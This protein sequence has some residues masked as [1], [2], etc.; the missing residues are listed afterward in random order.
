MV[1]SQSG[2]L[3][4]G[5]VNGPLFTSD[6][7]FELDV[8]NPSGIDFGTEEAAKI[9]LDRALEK[10][11]P[12][13]QFLFEPSLDGYLVTG[14]GVTAAADLGAPESFVSALRSFS[15][16]YIREHYRAKLVF[17]EPKNLEFVVSQTVASDPGPNE[18]PIGGLVTGGMMG[19]ALFSVA[20][21][22]LSLVSEG[23]HF[24]LSRPGKNDAD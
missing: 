20:Y 17:G 13:F 4:G 23:N 21:L 7:S 22:L 3:S 14:T 19:V 1:A 15:T 16:E 2:E 12:G 18:L 10:E 5:A 6:V 24:F 9:L 11:F 8:E